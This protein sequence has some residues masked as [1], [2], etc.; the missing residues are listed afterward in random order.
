MNFK[1]NRI[2]RQIFRSEG[3]AAKLKNSIYITVYM[4]SLQEDNVIISPALSYISYIEH[5]LEIASTY[6]SKIAFQILT[7][8]FFQTLHI[9]K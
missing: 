3:K 6:N 1:Y 4:F 8:T 7:D 2:Q 5:V 9:D